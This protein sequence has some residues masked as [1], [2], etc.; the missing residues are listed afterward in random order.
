MQ[1]IEHNTIFDHYVRL[2]LGTKRESKQDSMQEQQKDL[3][4]QRSKM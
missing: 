1:K 2:L 4:R 3:D